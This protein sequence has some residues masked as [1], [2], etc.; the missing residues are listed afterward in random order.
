MKMRV[1][2]VIGMGVWMAVALTA[3]PPPS[4]HHSRTMHFDNDILTDCNDMHVTF[5]GR[6]GVMQT[7]EKSF[8]KDQA[9]PLHVDQETN[10]GLQ[11]QGWD[12]DNYSVTLCKAAEP[13]SNA[14][15]LL[16]QVKL[17]TSGSRVSVSGPDNRD[18]WN[19]YLIVRVPKAAMLDV[20]VNNGPMSLYN[21]NGAVTAHAQNGPI[22]VHDCDGQLDLN[23]QNGPITWRG[24]SGKQSVRTQNGPITLELDGKTWNG[25]GLEAHAENGPVTVKVP[26]GFQTGMIIESDGHG[27]FSCHSSVCGEGRKT[28]EDSGEKRIEFG[29][30]PTLIRVS[31]VNGP[32]SVM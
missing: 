6:P 29:T 24:G 7:E 17:E 9:N 12:K 18:N 3:A 4:D 20:R 13:G 19:S 26:A 21:V 2:L 15:S 28:W 31:T 10:G 27:P 22:T 16:A 1:L 32:V 11:V 14:D 30:G 25:T 5:D 23:A 8:S